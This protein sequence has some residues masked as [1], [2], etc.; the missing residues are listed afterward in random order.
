MNNNN[1]QI[2]KQQCLKSLKNK[3]NPLLITLN[4]KYLPKFFD[5]W[6]LEIKKQ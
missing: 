6:L 1:V 3:L 4:L 2:N 5:F